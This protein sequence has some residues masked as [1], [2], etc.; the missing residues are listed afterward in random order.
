LA[1][2]WVTGIKTGETP[3]AGSCLVASGTLDGVSVISVVLGQPVHQLCFDES[4]ALLRYGASRYRLETLFE[5]GGAAAEA[6]LPY[7]D[8][9]K[10]ELVPASSLGMELGD[11]D[12]V[13]VSVVVDTPVVL[14]VMAG[15]DFGRIDLTIGG[16][17]IKSV[18]LVAAESVS[19]PSLGVKLAD[20][21]GIGR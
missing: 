19:E 14:P 6:A 8:G 3:T 4:E 16:T 10:L 13:T 11:E 15:E 12:S 1:Y 21:L 18:D 17:V 2:D 7:G 20:L 5:D 9:Q